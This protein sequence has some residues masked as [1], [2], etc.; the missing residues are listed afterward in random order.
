M[1]RWLL[2]G[3]GWIALALGLI[4]AL[5]P[6]LPTTPF[7]LLA[8]ACFARASKRCHN[9]LMAMPVLGPAIIDWETDRGV[10]AGNKI[11]ALAML[12]PS[13]MLTV[14]AVA[15]PAVVTIVLVGI[16]SVVTWVLLRLPTRP[17]P[18]S[19]RLGVK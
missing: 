5:L 10:T 11:L 6:L 13:T 9:W 1:W 15:T 3:I 4:G 18:T 16:A 19:R 2:I 8:A 17:R 14:S 12:W 7:A